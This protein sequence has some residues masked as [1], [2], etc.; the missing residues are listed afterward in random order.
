MGCMWANINTLLGLLVSLNK[1]P[2]ADHPHGQLL[3]VHGAGAPQV[4]SSFGT[5]VLV[6]SGPLIF[7]PSQGVSDGIGTSSRGPLLVIILFLL[8]SPLLHQHTSCLMLV[9]SLKLVLLFFSLGSLFILFLLSDLVKGSPSS[10]LFLLASCNLNSHVAHLQV[11][12]DSSHPS[13]G[14]RGHL[15]VSDWRALMVQLHGDGWGKISTG[16]G[17][18]VSPMFFLFLYL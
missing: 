10:F 18:C 15:R 7:T 9:S 5:F 1:A 12:R 8:P 3:V 11:I 13:G 14:S 17:I 2:Q 4:P 6:L 16:T